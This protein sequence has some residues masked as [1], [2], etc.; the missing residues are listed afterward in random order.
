[1]ASLQRLERRVKALEVRRT[2]A[3]HAYSTSELDAL[4]DVEIR[5][6]Y[7]QALAEPMDP[8]IETWCEQA[9]LQ[10]LI[11]VYE[12]IARDPNCQPWSEFNKAPRAP[13]QMKR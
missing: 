4:S 9:S 12:Q 13:G 1:M 5:R 11:M 7:D 6:L 10:D 3:D 2:T 8:V